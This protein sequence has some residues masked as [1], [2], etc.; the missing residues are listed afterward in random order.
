[1]RVVVTGASGNLGR[2]LLWQPRHARDA[3]RREFVAA[4]SRRQGGAGPLLYPRKIRRRPVA[5]A[6]AKEAP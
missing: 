3:V 1:M 4:L 6:T 5:A 2:A